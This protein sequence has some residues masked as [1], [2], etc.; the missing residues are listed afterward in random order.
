MTNNIDVGNESHLDI[1]KSKSNNLELFCNLLKACL[2]LGM[3][4][5]PYGV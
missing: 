1:R 4:T 3:F 5:L 2:G